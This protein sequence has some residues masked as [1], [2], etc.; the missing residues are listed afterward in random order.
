MK[1]IKHF[2]HRKGFIKNMKKEDVKKLD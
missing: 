2:F 1:E